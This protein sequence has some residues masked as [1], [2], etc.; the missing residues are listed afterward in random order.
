MSWSGAMAET[1]IL[2]E[3]QNKTKKTIKSIFQDFLQLFKVTF[4]NNNKFTIGF[5]E[6]NNAP[7]NYC[8]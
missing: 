1:N 6:E 2:K 4:M 5:R 7:L 8:L 3:K